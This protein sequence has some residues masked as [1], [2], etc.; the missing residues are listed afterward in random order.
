MKPTSST[1]A[2]RVCFVCHGNICR[3]PTAEG[4]MRHLVNAR[5]LA[6]QVKIESAGTGGWH[7]GDRPDPRT[8]RAALARGYKLES[9]AQQFTPY[10]FDRFDYILAADADNFEQ[11][12]RLAPDGAARRKVRLLRDFDP[13]SPAG[14]EVP[15]PYYG[16]ADGFERVLDICEA[17]CRGL[18]AHIEAELAV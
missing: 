4:V 14:S 8:R 18:L 9:F 2:V 5:G 17:A 10:F 11:L 7:V 3:S 12:L 15:D 6:G 1:K 16:G 13:A